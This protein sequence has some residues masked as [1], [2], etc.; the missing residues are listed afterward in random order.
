MSNDLILLHNAGN[1]CFIICQRYSVYENYITHFMPLVSFYTPWNQQKIWFS[2]HFRGHRK[3]PVVWNGLIKK[4]FYHLLHLIK[5]ISYW[6]SNIIL[7]KNSI[8]LIKLCCSHPVL[9]LECIATNVFKESDTSMFLLM[10]LPKWSA[11]L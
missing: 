6:F 4:K 3:R 2:D 9:T 8:Q 5:R 7:K 11:T 10:H 1:T